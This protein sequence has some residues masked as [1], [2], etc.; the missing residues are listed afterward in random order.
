MDRYIKA[1]ILEDIGQKFILIS[2]PR[3]V[4]KTT[5]TQSLSDSFQYLNFDI[6]QDRK[7]LIQQHFDEQKFA[8]QCIVLTCCGC[9]EQVLKQF[10]KIKKFCFG[11]V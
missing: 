5:F 4:G 8:K 3:Q 6:P 11:H 1:A 9:I 2:G 10:I 7:M